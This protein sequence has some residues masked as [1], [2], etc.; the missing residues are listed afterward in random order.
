MVDYGGERIWI[1]VHVW[2]NGDCSSMIPNVS[3]QCKNLKCNINSKNI[4]MT[5]KHRSWER[6]LILSMSSGPFS[7]K[8]FCKKKKLKN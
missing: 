2:H 7:G 5:N 1:H 4:I 8:A 6:E 3:T